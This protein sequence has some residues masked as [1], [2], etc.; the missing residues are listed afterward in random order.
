M[1]LVKAF[2]STTSVQKFINDSLVDAL[3][4]IELDAAIS[5]IKKISVTR[6]QRGQ[7]WSVINHLETAEI[8]SFISP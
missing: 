8:C 7:I 4:Q 6:D 5:A 1:D 2:R 3:T